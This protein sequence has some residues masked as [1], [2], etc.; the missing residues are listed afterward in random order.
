MLSNTNTVRL[1]KRNIDKIEPTP[2]KDQVFYRDE[3]LKGFALRVTERGVKSFVVEKRINGRV[4]R[5]TLGKYGSLTVEAARK[6]ALSLLGHIA[7]G[8]NPIAKKQTTTFKKMSLNMVFNDYLKARKDLKPRTVDGYV[9][10]L[11][12]VIPDWLNKPIVK[13][14][15]QM[16]AKRH[17][18]FGHAHSKAG[19]NHAMRVLRAVFNFAMHEYQTD[20]GKPIIIVNPVAYL[21]HIR[22]WFRIERRQTV[23]K[24]HQLRDWYFGL[25]NLLNEEEYAQGTMWRDYL[26]LL[27]LTGMRK[28][29]AASIKWED[30][31][32]KAR[33]FTLKD[34]KNRENHT[35]PMSDA[36]L[37]IF[38]RRKL[39]Q[40]NEFVFPADSQTGFIA[41][42]KK[43]VQK[44]EALSNVPFR[45]HDLRR[46]F[47]T[48]AESLDFPAYALKRLLN[49]KMSQDVT[50]G[51]IINDVERLRKPMQQITDF[52]MRHLEA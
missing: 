12:L 4:K 9:S 50:A 1:I 39:F 42:P 52:L 15:Q 49:H 23:I 14:T 30:V 35:L 27:L 13:I 8:E 11:N 7:R 24:P 37:D 48:T 19:A 5:M 47:A 21:S 18:E 10:V 32:I 29:E 28:T 31:D 41:E 16:V 3:L 38:K 44:V 20:E 51:Y 34:T 17:A 36:I 45:L 6:E 26:L 25:N 22:G 40:R 46:T 33:T 2:G 43:V